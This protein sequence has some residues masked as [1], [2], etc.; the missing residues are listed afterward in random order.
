MAH[1]APTNAD[2]VVPPITDQGCANGLEG[3]AKTRT[4]L[5]PM[6]A[7]SHG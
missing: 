5:A 1:A 2:S 6:G 7:T 4:A 3:N